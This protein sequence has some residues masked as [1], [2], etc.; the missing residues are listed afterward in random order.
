M[1]SYKFYHLAIKLTE[2]KTTKNN[3]NRGYLFAVTTNDS[4]NTAYTIYI[5]SIFNEDKSQFYK[6]FYYMRWNYID[7]WINEYKYTELNITCKN[8]KF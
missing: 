8:G 3:R 1:H 7:L 2:T 6:H 5:L 4:M